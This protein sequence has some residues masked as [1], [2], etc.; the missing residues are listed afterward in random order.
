MSQEDWEAI[1]D[2]DEETW[3]A[4][5]EPVRLAIEVLREAREKRRGHLQETTKRG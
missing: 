1:E 5:R 4:L 3:R 2:I